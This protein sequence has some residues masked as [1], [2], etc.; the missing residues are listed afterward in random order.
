MKPIQIHFKD[1][2]LEGKLGPVR[3]G[4]SPEE[5]EALLGKS[6]EWHQSGD[7]ILLCVYGWYFFTFLNFLPQS[8]GRYVLV[9]IH[10]DDLNGADWL[11]M[12]Y[13]H[14]KIDPW[15]L[16]HRMTKEELKAEL[17]RQNIAY[18]ESNSPDVEF[19]KL[20]KEASIGFSNLRNED[21]QKLT[22]YCV[23]RESF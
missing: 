8:E 3:F 20:S 23:T 17:D 4:M 18:T 6:R 22:L 12:D 11:N 16:K 9:Q 13:K 14:L 21:E 10:S 5:V 7:G 15:L 19:I 1:L 2:L